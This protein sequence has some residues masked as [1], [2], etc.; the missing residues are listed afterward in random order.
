[1]TV[2]RLDAEGQPLFGIEKKVFVVRPDGYIGFR[3]PLERVTEWREYARK[4]AL[5]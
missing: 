4:Y 3:G 5:G 2:V 1:V